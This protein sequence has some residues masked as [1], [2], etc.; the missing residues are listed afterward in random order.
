MIS[1]NNFSNYFPDLIGKLIRD[2]DNDKILLDTPFGNGRGYRVYILAY[3]ISKDGFFLSTE[4]KF[5]KQFYDLGSQTFN[6]DLIPLF[7]VQD[8]EFLGCVPKPKFKE[9]IKQVVE[10]ETIDGN[11]LI[12]HYWK[13]SFFEQL[14]S[15]NFKE[16]EKI[17]FDESSSKN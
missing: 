8:G 2:L 3:S 9:K 16:K 11:L 10:K 14:Q 4:S 17:F 1:T 5:D 13:I 6:I 7:R 12:D 15:D